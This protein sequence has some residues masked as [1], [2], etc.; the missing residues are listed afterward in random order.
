MAA[1]DGYEET[2][3]MNRLE[4]QF[5]TQSLQIHFKILGAMK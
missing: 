1:N 3:H 2:D 5:I 4:D